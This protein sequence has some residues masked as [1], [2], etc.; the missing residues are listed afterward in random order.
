MGARWVRAAWTVVA[1][2]AVTAVSV[3]LQPAAPAQSAIGD[4][5]TSSGTGAVRATAGS[6]MYKDEILWI[7]W[8][9]QNTSLDALPRSVWTYQQVGA[10]TRLE[11]QCT[12]SNRTGGS[13]RAYR[14][15]TYG[16]DGLE[17]L[18]ST[19]ENDLVSAVG[20]TASRADANFRIV[21]DTARLATYASSAF[22]GNPTRTQAITL[23]GLVFADAESTTAGEATRATPTPA[24]STTWRLLEAYPGDC[25]TTYSVHR[26]NGNQLSL[27]STGQCPESGNTPTVVAFAEGATRLDVVLDG[28]GQAAAAFGVFIGV[29]YGDAPASTGIAGAVVQPTWT[30]GTVA[31]NSTVTVVQNTVVMTS[32]AT[33]GAPTHRLGPSARTNLTPPASPDASGDTPDEDAFATAPGPITYYRGVT[34]SYTLAGIRCVGTASLTH[35]RVWLDWDRSGTF[36]ADEASTTA[37]CNTTSNNLSVSWNAIPNDVPPPEAAG[38]DRT[39]LRVVAA[40]SAAEL[41][42]TGFTVRGEVEDWPVLLRVPALAVTKTADVAN[43]PAAGGVVTYSVVAT[44]VGNGDYT[45]AN[46]ARLYDDLAGVTDD[47]TLGTPTAV[48]G[49]AVTTSGQVVSWTGPLAEGASVTLTIPVTV[50]TTPGDRVMTNVARVSTTTLTAAQVTCTQGSADETAQVCAR[51]A[52]YRS[53]VGVTKEAFRDAA[54]TTPVASGAS[55]APGTTV[56]WRYTVRNTGTTALTGLVLT[57]TATDTRTDANGTE[58]ATSTPVISCPGTPAVTPGT[59]VTIPSLAPG[60]SRVCT[61]SAPVGVL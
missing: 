34:T 11:V 60:A 39:F 37:T 4:A 32:M 12:L 20:M 61:A 29:D 28:A 17:N 23:G 15:G 5:T 3:A 56:H 33:M 49:G 7:N 26:S 8:G 25:D 16:A 57:D 31:A 9:P 22:T 38:G 48:P 14:S 24:N 21:C 54:F 50:R 55:L 18:Y 13:L 2:L 1:V 19:P 53:E 52:L 43:M 35:V 41:G 27:T 46:P 10:T 42:A 40:A 59:S 36:E 47:A 45:A 44:N 58:S 51:H 6:G 30:G